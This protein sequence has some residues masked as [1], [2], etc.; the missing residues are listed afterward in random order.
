LEAN[1]AAVAV[2]AVDLAAERG[3]PGR[4]PLCDVDV[5]ELGA[6][7]VLQASGESVLVPLDVDLRR[8]DA[9]ARPGLVILDD[10]PTDT[11]SKWSDF[12]ERF[13]WAGAIWEVMVG[14]SI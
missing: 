5:A 9:L 7:R 11:V 13:C 1:I 10:V 12:R 6:G 4:A 2:L 14:P 3:Q 8:V